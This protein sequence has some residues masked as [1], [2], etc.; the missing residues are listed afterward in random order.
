MALGLIGQSLYSIVTYN[1]GRVQRFRKKDHKNRLYAA[2]CFL[3]NPHRFSGGA[4]AG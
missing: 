2:C 3:C 1:A 4:D